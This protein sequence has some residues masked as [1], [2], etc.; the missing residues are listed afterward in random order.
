MF[1]GIV[2][3][4]SAYVKGAYV[5]VIDVR[6]ADIVLCAFLVVS[7]PTGDRSRRRSWS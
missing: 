4:E 6:F 1:G 3:G 2:G 5:T 7:L